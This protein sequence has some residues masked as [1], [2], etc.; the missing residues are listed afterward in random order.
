[1][2]S[3][4]WCC[5]CNQ[6]AT[7]TAGGFDDVFLWQGHGCMRGEMDDKFRKWGWCHRV[8]IG[9][10]VDGPLDLWDHGECSFSWGQV[11]LGL[12]KQ[13]LCCPE[14]S[15]H[16]PRAA[17]KVR[18]LALFCHCDYYCYW[19]ASKQ[20]TG[21]SQDHPCNMLPGQQCHG[22]TKAP[23]DQI[24]STN[25]YSLHVHTLMDLT[26]FLWGLPLSIWKIRFAQSRSRA[27][28]LSS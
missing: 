22:P 3:L 16:V 15:I 4:P 6:K 27:T 10:P 11:S 5:P 9:R 20:D 1:M 19:I 13:A 17:D 28:I 25:C 2:V 8:K 12:A 23:G 26:I 24:P 7:E 14:E 18:F 21:H